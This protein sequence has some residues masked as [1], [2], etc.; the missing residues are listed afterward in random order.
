MKKSI[1]MAAGL[2]LSANSYGAGIIRTGNV[3][4]G[5]DD[6]GQLNIP[7]YNSVTNNS[8]FTGLTYAPNPPGGDGTS[9][10]CLCEGWGVSASGVSGFANNAIGTGGLTLT[11]FNSDAV[12]GSVI[13]TYATS[14]VSLTGMPG[15][16]VTQAYT[17]SA[18]SA[19]FKN[20]VTI[21]NGTANSVT[22]VRY[23]RVMDWDIPPTEFSELVTIQGTA[24][25]SA[26]EYSSDNGFATADPLAGNPGGLLGGTVN[27]DFT[28]SGPSDHGAYFRF[29]F[30]TLSA[31]ESKSFD[32]FYGAASNEA[33]ALAAI[34]T[35]QAELYSFGQNSLPTSSS[36]PTFVFAFKG[37][38]GVAQVP[39]P[40]GGST[41]ALLA[42]SM[43]F[44]GIA[45]RRFFRK[46]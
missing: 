2:A 39:V 33:N 35:V 42:A 41:L 25:T 19:L 26:L 21:T 40:D 6:L 32:I 28:D 9:P 23:V 12:A 27:T 10:G 46:G 36:D 34:G 18:S 11:S 17:A 38:G 43:G 4:L 15:L 5:I 31:G 22:D 44:L 24:T 1:L 30:G 8:A 37:V 45:K 13:G 20:T 3:Y 29:N 7:S 16:T 14:S